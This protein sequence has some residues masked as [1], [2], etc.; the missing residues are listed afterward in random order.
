MRL[1][2][3]LMELY[4]AMRPILLVQ[5]WEILQ[6]E[7][8]MALSIVVM[9]LGV[10]LVEEISTSSPQ[11]LIKEKQWYMRLDTTFDYTTP[12]I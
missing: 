12:F 10:I 6:Q 3:Q 1:R 7:L 2:G 5:K 9:P 11:N 4:L 8:L